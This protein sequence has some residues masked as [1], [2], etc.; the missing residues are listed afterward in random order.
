MPN[1][2]LYD[3]EKVFNSKILKMTFDQI[4]NNE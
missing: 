3:V 2:R 4:K 1:N